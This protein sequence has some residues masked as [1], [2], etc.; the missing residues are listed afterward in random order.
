[1][2]EKIEWNSY[3]KYGATIVAISAV[4]AYPLYYFWQRYQV[5][6]DFAV[7]TAMDDL[8]TLGKRS[9]KKKLRGTAVVVGGRYV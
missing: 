2:F 5:R 1:M 7:H 4:S 9:S 3:Y 6:K 8:D